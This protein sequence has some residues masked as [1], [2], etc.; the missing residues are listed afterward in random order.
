VHHHHQD[1]SGSD[2]I[3]Y[4]QYN[5]DYTATSM[6]SIRSDGSGSTVLDPGTPVG[7]FDYS[8]H[9]DATGRYVTFFRVLP[10]SNGEESGS[11][12]WR[13]RADGSH[14]R[15]I[16][17]LGDV[18]NPV[19][20]PDGRLIAFE[21]EV[22]VGETSEHDIWLVDTDGGHL[23]NLTRTP[24]ISDIWPRWTASGHRLAY[25]TEA[26]PGGGY[27]IVLDNLHGRTTAVAADPGANEI[28]ATF[29]PNNQQVAYTRIADGSRGIYRARVGGNR[30]PQ[31]VVPGGAYADWSADGRR[32]AVVIREDA[33][34]SLVAVRPDGSH[35]RTLV[36]GAEALYEPDWLPRR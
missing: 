22:S 32:L 11:D 10:G 3:L 34:S 23:R 12:L 31:L 1:R 27:D 20:S 25:S 6:V 30:Q 21:R 8:P 16:T 26:S 13:M 24:D 29:S 4:W 7:A 17:H 2:R 18:E 19:S 36:A 5:A 9:W 33:G 15:Q 14:A 28:V 35:R